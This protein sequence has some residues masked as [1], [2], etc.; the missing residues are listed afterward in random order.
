ME[1]RTQ[2][3]RDAITSGRPPPGPGAPPGEGLAAFLDAVIGLASRNVGLL[4]AHEHALAT[5]KDTASA[6]DQ[7][8]LPVLA[9]PR[10]LAHHPGPPRT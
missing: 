7:P 6:R 10:V 2:A 3:L 4:M 9:R 1:E 5:R 8:C